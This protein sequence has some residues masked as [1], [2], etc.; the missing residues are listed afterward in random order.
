M[1]ET[2]ARSEGFVSAGRDDVHALSRPM[3]LRTL[4]LSGCVA[5][6]AAAAWI[7]SPE[8]YLQADLELGRLLRGM[9]AIKASFVMATIGIL[10]WRFGW[11]VSMPLASV[12]LAGAATIAG[13]SM[14]IW[15][16]THIPLAAMA[17]HVGGLALLVATW[18][19]RAAVPRIATG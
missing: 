2:I 19:D 8:N 6:V 5:S 15:Q 18:Q 4:L 9:A 12:Y 11:P 3:A 10:L 14:L 17:F 1:S 13:S 7:G 16:L